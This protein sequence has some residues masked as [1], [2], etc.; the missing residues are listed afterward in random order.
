M[1]V[2]AKSSQ[3]KLIVCST[4]EPKSFQIESF[5][6]KILSIIHSSIHTYTNVCVCVCVGVCVCAHVCVCAGTC[7]CVCVFVCVCVCVVQGF[8]TADTVGSSVAS[9]EWQ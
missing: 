4:F 6:N 2:Q 7:V 8:N 1:S 5:F 9:K 3:I